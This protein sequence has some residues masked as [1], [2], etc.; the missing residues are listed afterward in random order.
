MFHAYFQVVDH[1]VNTF[2]L[3]LICQSGLYV[4]TWDLILCIG[5][6][7]HACIVMPDVDVSI[8]EYVHMS[9]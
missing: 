6:Y 4:M 8:Y 1:V 9:C 3:S 5:V 7:V 2:R